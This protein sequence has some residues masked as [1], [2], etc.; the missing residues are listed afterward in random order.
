[1]FLALFLSIFMFACDSGDSSNPTDPVDPGVPN[2]SCANPAGGI[3]KHG[4]AISMYK[5]A[6]VPFG[7]SCQSETRKCE[8]G[9]LSGSFVSASCAVMAEQ[10]PSW[11]EKP[12][13]ISDEGLKM[14]MARTIGDQY[15]WIASD[16]N[17]MVP[18]RPVFADIPSCEA[19]VVN[20]GLCSRN[21]TMCKIGQKVFQCHNN[22]TYKVFGWV[23]LKQGLDH[24]KMAE[25]VKVDMHW[26]AGCLAG[27]CDPFAGPVY[28]DKWGYFEFTTTSLMDTL[29][30]NGM[31]KYYMFCQNG[32]PIG[33]GGQYMTTFADKPIG[34]FKQ[35][36]NVPDV[37]SDK[38]KS[39]D[40]EVLQHSKKTLNTV[41]NPNFEPIK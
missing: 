24:S 1:M 14:G 10:E 30:L 22:K 26:F 40:L 8:N 27:M 37:C 13:K 23:Y 25:G 29:R 12:V 11:H 31:P 17:D 15:T 33:G 21:S 32:N 19:S 38:S 2:A 20:G 7:Q 41:L 9:V 18:P 39:L 16:Y 4:E 5:D 28:T 36:L 6:E 35:L 34:P 3:V